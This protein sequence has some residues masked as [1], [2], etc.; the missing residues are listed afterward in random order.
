[1]N[2][3]VM[4]KIILRSK[5]WLEN[6]FWKERKKKGAG[7]QEEGKKEEI[8]KQTQERNSQGLKKIQIQIQEKGL[9]SV[10]KSQRDGK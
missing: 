6:S 2:T 8:E 9:S 5:L 1:M 7:G 4:T 3:G 10:K